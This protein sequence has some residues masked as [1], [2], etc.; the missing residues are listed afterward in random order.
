VRADSEELARRLFC[1]Y[2]SIPTSRQ[3]EGICQAKPIEDVGIPA[4]Q[5][6]IEEGAMST[7]KTEIKKTEF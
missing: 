2:Y 7:I 3:N 4:G 5:K 6:V 1:Q